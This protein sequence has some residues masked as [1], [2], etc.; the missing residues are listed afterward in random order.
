MRTDYKPKACLAGFRFDDGF[1]MTRHEYDVALDA[2]YVGRAVL[3]SE[4]RAFVEATR[5]L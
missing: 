1:L 4:L 3:W 2:L 5:K